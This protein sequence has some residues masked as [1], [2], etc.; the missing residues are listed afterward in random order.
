[1]DK[2]KTVNLLDT[3]KTLAKSLFDECEFAFDALP[4][5]KDYIIQLSKTL[6]KDEFN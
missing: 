2:L 1:M 3:E 6:D 5:I 4:K